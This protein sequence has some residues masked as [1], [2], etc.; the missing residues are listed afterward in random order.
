MQ[1][2]YLSIDAAMVVFYSAAFPP[3]RD[4]T[5]LYQKS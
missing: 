5:T 3:T 4:K 1:K 2:L